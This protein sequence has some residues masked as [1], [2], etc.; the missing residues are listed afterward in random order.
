LSGVFVVTLAAAYLLAVIPADFVMSRQMLRG[1]KT[2]A[3]RTTAADLHAADT[4]QHAH[5][6]ATIGH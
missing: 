6:A 2:R 3:E 1:V 4:A 5:R